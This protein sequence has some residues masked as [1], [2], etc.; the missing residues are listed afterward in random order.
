MS[1]PRPRPVLAVA[2][3][4]AALLGAGAVAH[5][6]PARAELC[7]GF[8]DAEAAVDETIGPSLAA[9]SPVPSPSPA[10]AWLCSGGWRGADGLCYGLDPSTPAPGHGVSLDHAARDAAL[11]SQRPALR[12]AVARIAPTL[13][14]LGAKAPGFARRLERPPRLIAS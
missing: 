5:A 9:P 1:M 12:R 13:I 3:A 14:T 8:E 11:G 10:E 7:D 4:A 2:A 6:G